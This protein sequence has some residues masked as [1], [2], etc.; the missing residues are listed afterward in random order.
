VVR[1]GEVLLALGSILL[2][3]QALKA[4][5][6]RAGRAVG[7]GPFIQIRS[8][9]SRGPLAATVGVRPS[10]LMVAWSGIALAVLFVAPRAGLVDTSLARIAMGAALGG[11]ASNLLD[12]VVRGCVIDYVDVRVWPVF[13]LG[14]AAI[15][16]GVLVALAAG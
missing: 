11:A 12:L 7:L 8:A 5:V 1:H 16:T 3:D 4:A 13:N 6:L 10:L 9:R 14:D 15:V 2:V